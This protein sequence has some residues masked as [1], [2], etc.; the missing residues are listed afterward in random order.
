MTELKQ[1]CQDLFLTRKPTPAEVR[2]ESCNPE[3]V[4]ELAE[5]IK[6]FSLAPRAVKQI[7]EIE[8]RWR[9]KNETRN[10]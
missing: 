8:R 7:R 2:V 5:Q 1:V 4:G 10:G 9:K 6:G 3:E